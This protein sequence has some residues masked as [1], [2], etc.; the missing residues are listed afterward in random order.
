MLA[1]Y[2]APLVGTHLR[3]DRRALGGVVLGLTPQV[4][5]PVGKTGRGYGTLRAGRSVEAQPAS[6]VGKSWVVPMFV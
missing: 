1:A 5:G 2:R 3:L 4:G 6:H